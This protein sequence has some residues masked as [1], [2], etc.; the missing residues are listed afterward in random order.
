MTTGV[1]SDVAARGLDIP[2]VSHVFNFDVPHHAEDYVHRIGR[3]G[4]AGLEGTAISLA[5]SEDDK[6]LAAIERLINKKIPWAEAPPPGREFKEEDERPRGTRPERGRGGRRPRLAEP[7]HVRSATPTVQPK[8]AEA[9][10]RRPVRGAP[11]PTTPRPS[12]HRDRDDEPAVLGLGDH[13][14]SFL[15]RPVRG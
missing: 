12:R 8:P 3:T 13:V 14:P 2:A 7:R 5:S 10:E 1:A 9:K 4:R 6:L 15:L 11:A